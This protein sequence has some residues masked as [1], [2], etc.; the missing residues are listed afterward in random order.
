MFHEGDFDH[1]VYFSWIA[2]NVP[3]NGISVNKS[4]DQF[5]ERLYCTFWKPWL[6]LNRRI[7][8]SLKIHED[9]YLSSLLVHVTNL[10]A[11]IPPP[12]FLRHFIT[13]PNFPLHKGKKIHFC[14]HSYELRNKV[15]SIFCYSYSNGGSKKIQAN[16]M[17]NM[18]R[19]F[20]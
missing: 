13:R 10:A 1:Q 15:E 17:I 19:H 12:S 7:S 14:A 3:V 9:I 20:E 2:K 6:G 11:K 18:A 8:C 16:L 4:Q 5:S